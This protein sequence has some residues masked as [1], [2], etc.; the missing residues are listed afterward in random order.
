MVW[1]IGSGLERLMAVMIPNGTSKM[2]MVKI[3]K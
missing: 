1:L 3:M 2:N